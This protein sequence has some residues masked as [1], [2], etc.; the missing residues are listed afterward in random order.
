MLIIVIYI[1][2]SFC[3][4]LKVLNDYN[5]LKLHKVFKYT[6]F[7]SWEKLELNNVVRNV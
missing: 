1:L 7:I 3:L 4:I 2:L 5:F 6:I